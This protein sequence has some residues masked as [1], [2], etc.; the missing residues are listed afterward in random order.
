MTE[1]RSGSLHERDPI[2]RLIIQQQEADRARSNLDSL[3]YAGD[4]WDKEK[5][6]QGPQTYRGG[7][8]GSG[9]KDRMPGA[10]GYTVTTPTPVEYLM[11]LLRIKKFKPKRVELKPKKRP[12]PMPGVI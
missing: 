3:P 6:Y 10:N 5:D 7:N 9:T 11:D 2:Q 12:N 8:F 1:K 4:K